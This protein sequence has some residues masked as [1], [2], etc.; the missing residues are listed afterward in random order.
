MAMKSSYQSRP[1]LT[2]AG[3]AAPAGSELK[4]IRPPA[5][6]TGIP[7]CYNTRLCETDGKD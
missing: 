6:A 5:V 2:S 1:D 7:L 4:K 3:R